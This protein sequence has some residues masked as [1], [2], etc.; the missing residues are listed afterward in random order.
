MLSDSDKAKYFEL[1]S[2][3]K[4][5]Y[6]AEKTVSGRVVFCILLSFPS[7]H[8]ALSCGRENKVL[9]YLSYLNYRNFSTSSHDFCFVLCCAS[10]V[11]LSGGG[12]ILTGLLFYKMKITS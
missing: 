12:K 1:M 8:I 4:V 9:S 5:K 6:N 11:M 2:G 10:C 7:N 3:D